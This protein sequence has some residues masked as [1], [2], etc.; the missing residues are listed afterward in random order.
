MAK[1]CIVAQVPLNYEVLLFI[2]GMP[3]SLR[4]RKKLAGDQPKDLNARTFASNAGNMR[5]KKKEN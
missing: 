2:G 1:E 3:M 5:P 4:W